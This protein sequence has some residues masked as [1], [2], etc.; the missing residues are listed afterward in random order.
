MFKWYYSWT[1]WLIRSNSQSALSNLN[2][3]TEGDELNEYIFEYSEFYLVT[4]LQFF[5]FSYCKYEFQL[6][7]I[8]LLYD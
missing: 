1:V 2:L 6:S 5:Y 4:V 7:V 3:Q 8:D